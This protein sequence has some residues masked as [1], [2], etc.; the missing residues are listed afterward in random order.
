M[1]YVPTQRISYSSTYNRSIYYYYLL[2]YNPIILGWARYEMEEKCQCQNQ[3]EE[4]RPVVAQCLWVI[5]FENQR[6]CSRLITNPLTFGM[7]WWAYL[8]TYL[9]ISIYK[10]SDLKKNMSSQ[11]LLEYLFPFLSSDVELWKCSDC[12][13]E[14]TDRV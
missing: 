7:Y 2:Y 12:Y 6:K 10:R 11:F 4:E 13:F 8:L 5:S 3:R 9:G 1:Q 14:I